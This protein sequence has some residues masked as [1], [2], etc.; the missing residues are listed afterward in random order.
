MYVT[1]VTY[2]SFTGI[3]CGP[4]DGESRSELKHDDAPTLNLQ[5]VG[6]RNVM[7]NHRTHHGTPG[8]RQFSSM[9]LTN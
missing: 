6:L 1:N 4:L 3:Y 2:V 7:D 8:V 5:R 9:L